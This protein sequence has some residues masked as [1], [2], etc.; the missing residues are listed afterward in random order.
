[1]QQKSNN[2][3]PYYVE[4]G[5][6]SEPYCNVYT[7]NAVC[8]YDIAAESHHKILFKGLIRLLDEAESD[9]DGD[10]FT[11]NQMVVNQ[12]AGNWKVKESSLVPL[13]ERLRDLLEEKPRIRI[14]FMPKDELIA[15]L[16]ISRPRSI[17]AKR[18]Q[19]S[20][21][22]IPNISTISMR[23]AFAPG[24]LPLFIKEQDMNK[25]KHK[26]K[27]INKNYGP[28]AAISADDY[29][30]VLPKG[31]RSI[32]QDKKRVIQDPSFE[33]FTMSGSYF[34]HEALTQT[35]EHNIIIE[36]V[37]AQGKSTIS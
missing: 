2:A 16:R 33:I 1:M 36:G 9:V 35:I 17:S 20:I 34:K 10:V 29:G 28:D 12:I 13:V 30:Y 14:A 7:P 26:N 18:R 11:C 6:G 4:S 37:A 3:D 32:M 23:I 27:L 19:R 8:V 15:K 21:P 25:I 5:G 24:N 22:T 31:R